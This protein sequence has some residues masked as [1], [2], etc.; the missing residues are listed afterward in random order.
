M[1]AKVLE[2]YVDKNTQVLHDIGDTVEV[3]DKRC[4]EINATSYGAFLMPLEDETKKKPTK[5]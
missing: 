2:Q 4:E 5:K 3:T 1:R